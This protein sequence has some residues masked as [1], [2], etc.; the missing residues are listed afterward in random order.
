M[1]LRWISVWI[2]SCLL[3]W[4]GFFACGKGRQPKQE[5]V[6][7]DGGTTLPDRNVPTDRRVAPPERK[8]PEPRP[9]PK[10]E[11]PPN[12]RCA[13]VFSCAKTS[14]CSHFPSVACLDKC[15]TD[16]RL[17]GVGRQRLDALKSCITGQCKPC[18]DDAACLSKC[19]TDKCAKEWFACATDEQ[20]GADNCKQASSCIQGCA[21][22]TEC[23]AQ[24][25]LKTQ[26][27]AQ[28]LYAK[29]ETCKEQLKQ[30]NVSPSVKA[31]CYRMRLSCECPE[32]KPGQGAGTCAQY[33]KCIEPCGQDTCCVA[34][35]RSTSAPTVL[36]QADTFT[37]CAAEKCNTSCAPNDKACRGKCALEQCSSEYLACSCPGVQAPGSGSG[38]CKTALT[39]SQNCSLNDTCC[40]ARCT[41][42]MSAR[43]YQTYLKFVRCLPKCGCS[44]T[45]KACITKCAQG[46]CSSEAFKC[47]T[48]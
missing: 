5:A 9:E 47:Y 18:A 33:L 21:D 37:L 15:A 13:S 16:E 38:K 28:T 25:L 14:K 11:P 23:I 12:L 17:S 4:N 1:H 26:R 29:N 31:D 30:P 41:A 2:V 7:K 20:G 3:L 42:Q 46:T 39:C 44:A 6:Q 32:S 48:N 45:D 10:P 27:E 35:C 19:V 34:K 36:L 22:D 24:C 8:A 43:N 40:I